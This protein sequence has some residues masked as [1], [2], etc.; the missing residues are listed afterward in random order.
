MVL[1]YWKQ[2]VHEKL[3]INNKAFIALERIDA[4]LSK[5]SLGKRR[6]RSPPATQNEEKRIPEQADYD[7]LPKY[8]KEL[9][10]YEEELFENKRIRSQSVNSGAVRRREPVSALDPEVSDLIEKLQ[11]IPTVEP[12]PL[13]SHKPTIWDRETDTNDLDQYTS[14]GIPT[15]P[16]PPY[17]D[18]DLP[19]L[20]QE[21]YDIIRESYMDEHSIDPS[22]RTAHEN[23][24]NPHEKE[25][26]Q[27]IDLVKKIP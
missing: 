2:R 12:P 6:G 18:P 15:V 22:F 13:Y 19:D 14:Q 3:G 5:R 1:H 26:N 10:N 27:Y 9:P 23:I 7:K 24:D 25:L 4:E 20:T 17:W 21:Q 16:L 8:S 11:G